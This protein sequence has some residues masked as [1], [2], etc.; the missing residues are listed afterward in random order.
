MFAQQS[1][2]IVHI[3]QEIIEDHTL[4][5]A[6]QNGIIDVDDMTDDENAKC[7]DSK[8]RKI[9]P[10]KYAIPSNTITSSRDTDN[11]N[12]ISNIISAASKCAAPECFRIPFFNKVGEKAA[13]YCKKHAS[14]DM[15]DVKRHKCAAPSCLKQPFYNK[16]GEKTALYCKKHTSADMVIVGQ[17]CCSSKQ[18]SY[19]KAGEV[20]L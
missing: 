1:W 6:D 13:L 17:A 9:D 7:P 10:E 11:V 8:R 2:N 3:K 16:I 12:E 4:F 5:S 14:S 20:A 19:N 18:S 15:V